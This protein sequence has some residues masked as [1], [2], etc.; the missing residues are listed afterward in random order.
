MQAVCTDSHVLTI[1][2]QQDY[3]SMNETHQINDSASEEVMIEVLDDSEF[4]GPVNEQFMVIAYMEGDTFDGRV[5]VNPSFVVIPIEDNDV[6][7]GT[8][9]LLTPL[10]NSWLC[11]PELKLMG[12]ASI[13]PRV[14]FSP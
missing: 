2:A 1:T 13:K 7:P 10:S 6:R 3:T 9:P 4:E 12:L 11:I 14:S 5:Q 8:S